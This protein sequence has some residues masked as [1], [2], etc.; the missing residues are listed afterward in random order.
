MQVGDVAY[1]GRRD[2]AIRMQRELFELRQE[3][4]SHQELI[5]D[6][7]Q[8][9]KPEEE[10]VLLIRRAFGHHELRDFH[11]LPKSDVAPKSEVE[12]SKLFH[13]EYYTPVVI[14]RGTSDDGSA[15]LPM[16][17]FLGRLTSAPH[18]SGR[19]RVDM[20]T[21][22][23]QFL[24]GD[25]GDG[26]TTFLC[27]M[28]FKNWSYFI[29]RKILPIRFN[30][31]VLMD[32]VV[33]PPERILEIFIDTT[34][35]WLRDNRNICSQ[36][37][38]DQL[39][40]Y[41]RMGAAGG[42][43]LPVRLYNLVGMIRRRL[44]LSPMF[45]VDNVDFLYHIGDRGAFSK[46][47]TNQ[48]VSAYEAIIEI[49]RLFSKESQM[50]S[51][52]GINILYSVR[53]DTLD[54]IKSKRL[55]VP[56]PDLT[57]R[58][59]TLRPVAA[60][61][62][63]SLGV[64]DRRFDL[65]RHLC[66][67]IPEVAKREGFIKQIEKLQATYKGRG[68]IGNLVF[69][70]L[71]RLSRH[72]LRDIIDHFAHYSWIERRDEDSVVLSRRFISQYSPSILSYVLN[73]RRRYC[74]FNGRVPNLYLINATAPSLEYGVPAEFKEEHFAT[75]W[76]KRLILQY[77][78]ATCKQYVDATEIVNVF[79][80]RNRR[81]YPENLVRYI[82][83]SLAQVPESE[84][85]KVELGASGTGGQQF[86][87][88]K[89]AL[90]VRGRFLIEGF[91]DSF[92]YLQLMIDDWRLRLPKVMRDDFSYIEPDYGYLVSDPSNY[93]EH[94]K[95]VLY[96]KARQSVIFAI[97]LEEYL[98]AEKGLLPRVYARLTGAG[99]RVPDVGDLVAR[100][101]RDLERISHAVGLKALI[102]DQFCEPVFINAQ[103]GRISKIVSDCVRPQRELQI[104][105]YG[106]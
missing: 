70:D 61:A 49:F 52:L 21:N 85:I 7:A 46:A 44:N 101:V 66:G 57:D 14:K 8:M 4:P 60:N 23:V 1:K 87:I 13:Q 39:Y 63:Q 35:S 71:W 82:A 80:G 27:N 59:A 15:E 74:Q 93:T 86:Y 33:P 58:V 32:H 65:I 72:G 17:D 51:S 26:K 42:A 22:N 69:N 64:I 81:G 43:D 104:Y 100:V 34:L 83:G 25:V 53:R 94:V 105:A 56:L 6:A 48:Q 68:D 84:C 5:R 9:A 50:L 19:E 89:T 55:E 73:G 67:G 79:C 18:F 106:S 24:I 16:A 76:L 47:P 37:D 96:G 92:A 45:V 2:A 75:F 10:F 36:S 102:Y 97:F 40:A 103:R 31:D 95:N 99:V 38:A 29:N 98:E 12:I 30:V 11:R 3:T 28:I 88:R 91:A 54:Y 77:L 78:Q 62:E 90:T 41:S 20:S